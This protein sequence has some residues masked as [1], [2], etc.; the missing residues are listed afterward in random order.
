MDVTEQ[1]QL[2][3]RL[4]KLA[5]TDELTGLNNRRYFFLQPT[6]RRL[7]QGQGSFLVRINKFELFV[8][9]DKSG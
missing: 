3:K 2:K 6:F 9:K 7:K 4:A 5:M 1:Y 8:N